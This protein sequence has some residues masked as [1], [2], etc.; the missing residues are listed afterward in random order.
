[1]KRFLVFTIIFVLSIVY[2]SLAQKPYNN[3]VVAKAGSEEITYGDL[4]KAFKKNMNRQ[5]AKLWEVAKDSVLDFLDLYVNYRLKVQDAIKRGFDKDSAV[6][7]DIEQNKRILAESYLFEKNLTE[8]AVE[9]MVKR[10]KY[11]MEIAIILFTYP[12]PEISTDRV[13]AQQK[14]LQTIVRLKKGEKFE[15]LAMELSDDKETAKLGGRIPSLITSGRVQRPIEDAIY[16]LNVGEYYPQP[17]ETKYGYFIIKLL[18]K[19]ERTDVRASHILVPWGVQN[20]SAAARKTADSLYALIKKGSSFEKLARDNSE[21]PASAS[22][23]GALGWYS[24][25]FGFDKTGRHIVPEMENTLY[26]MKDGEIRG[27]IITEYGVHILRR[28]S[29]RTVNPED[30]REE[31][32]KLYKKIYF[33][34]DKR[35]YIN[36]IRKNYG[37][38]IN[39]PV[40]KELLA[41]FD[42]T[43]TNLDSAWTSAV[44]E[45]LLD[46]ILFQIDGKKTQVG[47]FI[48]MMNDR[49]EHP[50]LRGTPLTTEG[51]ENA[52]DKITDPIV[53]SKAALTLEK[54]YPGFTELLNEFRD[55]IL[56]FKVEADEVWDK[57]KFDTLLAQKYYDTTK[58]RY[59]TEPTYDLSEIYVLNDSIAKLVYAQL[60]DGKDFSAM[61]AQY[62]QRKGFREKDG[63][64]G[65]VNIKN[66]EIAKMLFEKGSTKPMLVSPFEF[67]KGWS[68][69]K[70]NSYEP[71]R[72]KTFEEAIPDFAS[73]FQDQMQQ[74]LSKNWIERLRKEFNVKIFKDVLESTLKKQKKLN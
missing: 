4:E 22:N 59:K 13:P 67:E 49:I 74:N 8:P 42:T 66:N 31:V 35:E 14:A 43:K 18:N 26:S 12:L 7:A 19:I 10:R 6:I 65:N 5:D 62:T 52:I 32:K 23:G 39:H 38:E 72:Q 25:V 55:G 27:G 36:K 20:D 58:T 16:S 17:I 9:E 28:D 54:D 44:P 1:M 45:S 64:W 30:E 47:K 48:G 24:R 68:I 69:V 70:I 29:T 51:I 3:E 15:N 57:L 60:K 21:D 73:S 40:L 63:K 71:S 11:E 2:T 50:L 56:L 61:A 33:N 46:Q 41:S 34:D 53:L 37:F